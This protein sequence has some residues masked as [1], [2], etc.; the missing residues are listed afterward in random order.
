MGFA[1]EPG[2]APASPVA[3]LLRALSRYPKVF[4]YKQFVPQPIG[5]RYTYEN[6]SLDYTPILVFNQQI[7]IHGIERKIN[8]P[9][10]I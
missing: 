9:N 6:F 5:G 4:G 10:N 3:D 1:N 2:A 7:F 8:K